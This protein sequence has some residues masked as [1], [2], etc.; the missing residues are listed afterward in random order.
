M[1]KA[2]A[3]RHSGLPRIGA[4][5]IVAHGGRALA[6]ACPHV[7]SG[8]QMPIALRNVVL[9]FACSVPLLAQQPVLR[10]QQSGS[11]SLFQAVSVSATDARVAWISGHRG[12]Y[13]I[14]TDG[15]ASWQARV[16]P[17]RDSLEFRDVHAIDARRAWLM[18]A[19]TGTKSGIFR[20]TDAGAT[21]EQVFANRDTAAFYDCM[22]FVDERHAFAFSD[23]VNGRMP[24]AQ[25]TNGREW[26]VSSIPSQDGEGGFAASGSCAQASS[27]G[28]G[29]IGTGT[30]AVPRVLHSTD[31]WKTWTAAEVP[32]VRGAGAGITALAFRDRNHGVAVGGTIAGAATGARAA[33]TTDGGRT[34]TVIPD[35]PFA[36]P[37]YGAAYARA[38]G[39]DRLVVVGPGGAAWSADDGASWT[40]L[41]S[42][43]YW[44]VG[45]GAD[46]S[47]FMVG[48]KGRVVRIE[49]APA[50]GTGTAH[51][52]PPS[53]AAS[54]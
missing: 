25:T 12:T 6:T 29:W 51:D 17:G 35:P 27:A 53:Q 24:L 44:S 28:D 40:M 41:D 15:G 4:T 32:L 18:A 23:A 52:Q 26:S 47:G 10:V 8:A 50:A 37:A 43:S 48:P 42:A 36:G 7:T 31:R 49:W 19:G 22:A 2:V 16:M 34:W 21:W 33:R 9:S 39:S 14:T 30:A 5:V 45:F 38:G 1:R 3:G 13:A 46:G 20:T 54:R 11:L